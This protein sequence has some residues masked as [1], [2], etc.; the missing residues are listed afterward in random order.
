MIVNWVL[1]CTTTD[2]T[3]AR[4]FPSLAALRSWL[5][6]TVADQDGAVV[7]MERAVIGPPE[8]RAPRGRPRK[9]G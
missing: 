6:V 5:D 9:V 2:G 8:T 7:G 4:R 1:T 3:V